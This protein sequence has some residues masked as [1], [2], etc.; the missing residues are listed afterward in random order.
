MAASFVNGTHNAGSSGASTIAAPS[1]SITSGNTIIVGVSN[2]TSGAAYVT[3][4][5]DSYG[6]TYNRCGN[7]GNGDSSHTMEMWIAHNVTGGGS[8]VVTATF[9]TSSAAYRVIMVSQYSGIAASGAYDSEAAVLITGDNWSHTTNSLNTT[10]ADD[11]VL[12]FFVAWGDGVVTGADSPNS[13]RI[14]GSGGAL[15]EKI[16]TTAGSYSVSCT[17]SSVYN[18]AQVCIAKSFKISSAAATLNQHSYRYL[19]D[20]GDEGS[21]T[22]AAALNTNVTLSPGDAFRLRFLLDATGDPTGKQLQ[23][24]RRKRPSGGAFGAWGKVN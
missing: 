4:V 2:Y 5:A 14:L 23:L 15:V 20:D 11:L 1:L 17:V 24:E 8:N 19:N 12:G 7:V 16:A 6:N 10:A 22:F 21:S 9:N 18:S 13:A 3:G